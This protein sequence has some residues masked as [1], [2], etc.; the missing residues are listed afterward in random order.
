[1]CDLY[2]RYEFEYYE[3]GVPAFF[4]GGV[5]SDGMTEH[6]SINGTQIRC[7]NIPL[8]TSFRDGINFDKSDPKSGKLFLDQKTNQ[9][10]YNGT[11]DPNYYLV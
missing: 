4:Q 11:T 10:T 2:N 8:P 5:D 9:L 1:M 6:Y 3:K 7:S